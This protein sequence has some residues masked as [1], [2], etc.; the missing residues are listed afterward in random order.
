MKAAIFS[1][2]S[3]KML[4]LLNCVIDNFWNFFKYVELNQ[5]FFQLRINTQLVLFF[6]WMFLLVKTHVDCSATV[7]LTD[8]TETRINQALDTETAHSGSAL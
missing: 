6:R 5:L 3:L 4:S 8:G 1:I 7:W 2:N